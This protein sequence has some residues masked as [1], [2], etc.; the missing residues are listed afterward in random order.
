MTLY[1][2]SNLVIEIALGQR[3]AN[4]AEAI[5]GFAQA[6]GVEMAVPTSALFEPF[7]RVMRQRERRRELRNRVNEEIGVLKRSQPHESDAQGLTAVQELFGN[8]EDREKKR[9]DE[10]VQRLISVATVVDVDAEVYLEAF[11]FERDLGFEK[12]TDAIICAAV[13]RHLA[14]S[15]Q[16]GPHVF[17]TL[18]KDFRSD[19][20]V[21]RFGRLGCAVAFSFE[22]CAQR[23]RIDP[24][25]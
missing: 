9:L 22:E 2:E 24:P 11:A 20:I 10:T 13:L 15:N 1:V 3:H 19:D 17:A 12:M 21:E 16:P 8:I 6:G 4:V 25:R 5:L 23:L 14:R 18:D 7:T